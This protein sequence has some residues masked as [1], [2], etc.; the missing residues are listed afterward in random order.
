MYLRYGM[1]LT[2][3]ALMAGVVGVAHAEQVAACGR[4][5]T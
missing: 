5:T 4:A 3:C 2:A 1:A